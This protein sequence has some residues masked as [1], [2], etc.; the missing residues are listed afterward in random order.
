MWKRLPRFRRLDC[1][2]RRLFRRGVVLLLA[3]SLSL[4]LRGFVA[5]QAALQRFLSDGA[6]GQR[7]K[8]AEKNACPT[9]AE[10]KEVERTVRVRAAAN[11]GV[12]HPTCLEQSLALWWLL[13]RQGIDPSVRIGA[14]KATTGFAAHAGVECDGAAL[15][16]GDELHAHYAVFDAAF[17]AQQSLLRCRR[18]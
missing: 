14:N 18:F 5:T 9:T 16:E 12:G 1:A 4:R 8:G 6:P 13:R 10:S 3:I 7:K 11:Y 17:P 2:A 15:N